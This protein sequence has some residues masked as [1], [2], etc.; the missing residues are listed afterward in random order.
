MLFLAFI[1][2]AENP[3]FFCPLPIYVL[4]CSATNLARLAGGEEISSSGIPGSGEGDRGVGKEASPGR[5]LEK[6]LD[7]DFSESKRS[8][9]D[10]GLPSGWLRVSSRSFSELS[11]AS[12]PP[13]VQAVLVKAWPDFF[14]AQVSA[15]SRV[16]API[17]PVLEEDGE[18]EVVVSGEEDE[19]EDLVQEE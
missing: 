15:G 3:A 4:A 17:C 1:F 5:R 9:V 11:Q 14:Q 12:V 7:S 6:E 13:E 18:E 10:S 8:D 2:A 16:Q 19:V